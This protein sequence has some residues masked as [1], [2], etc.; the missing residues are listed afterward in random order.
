MADYTLT[1]FVNGVDQTAPA[2]QGMER[3]GVGGVAVGN[4]LADVAMKAGAAIAG[5][6][7]GTLDAAAQFQNATATFASVAGGALAEAGIS[8][9]DVKN[10][11]LEMGAV[12]Q[13]SAAEAQQAMIELAKGG[14]P[15]VDVMGQATDAT[16]NLAAAGEVQLATAA[17]IV[18]KQLGV[19]ASTGVTAAQV[20]DTLAQAANAST[21]GVEELALGLS[22][23]GGVAQVSGVSFQDLNQTLAMIIPGF[24][25]ASDAG[26]SFK[27]M[28]LALQGKSSDAIGVMQQLGII[29]TD[30]A[31]IADDLGVTFDGSGKS[32][33][34]LNKA[35]YENVL[36]NSGATAGTKAFDDAMA[37]FMGDFQV[38]TFYDANGAL[39]DMGDIAGILQHSLAGLSE[40]QKTAALNT[41][42]GTD[43]YR[44]AAF[45]AKAGAEGFDAMGVSMANAGTAAEQAA[46]RNQTFKF[47]WDSLLGTMET[48]QIVIGSMLLPILTSL[49]NDAL[50]PAGNAVL[51]VIQSLG[52]AGVMSSEFAESMDL[53][54]Q[55]LG[56]PAN[57]LQNIIIFLQGNFMPVIA[58]LGTAILVAVVPGFIAWAAVAGAAALATL[59]ALAPA[60]AIGAAVALLYVAWQNNFLGIQDIT[61][62]VWAT[63]QPYLV[64]LVDW[65]SVAIPAAIQAAAIL[66]STVLWPALQVV[67]EFII[68]TVIPALA[69]IVTWL[70][71]NIPPAIATAVAAFQTIIA[72][73]SAFVGA[74]AAGFA[75]A[76][77]SV[78]SGIATITTIVQAG[79]NTVIFVT[80]AAWGALWGVIGPTVN[81]IVAGVSAGLATI[82]GLWSAGWAVLEG[83]A[84]AAWAAITTA[85]QAAGAAI[86][87]AIQSVISFI[88]SVWGGAQQAAQAQTT[89]A[90]TAIQTM[91][92]GAML[93]IK[94]AI[95]TGIAVVQ[96]IMSTAWA[97]VVAAAQNDFGKIPAI[98]QAGW[99]R[100]KSIMQAGVSAITAVAGTMAAAALSLG[101]NIVSGILSGV[102]SMGS[103]LS[104]KLKSMAK[105]ALDAAKS[106]LGIKSPSSVMADQVGAPIAQGVA[107]GIQAATPKATAAMSDMAGK[108]VSMVSNSVGA[109]G[110]LAN[111]GA[112]PGGAIQR[113]QAAMIA[114]VQMLD[115]VNTVVGKGMLGGAMRL[116][117]GVNRVMETVVKGVEAFSKL[118]ELGT[119]PPAAM[120]HFGDAL[121]QV[122]VVL[123]NINALTRGPMLTSASIMAGNTEKIVGLIGTGAE[124]FTKL[125]GMGPVSVANVQAFGQ[126]LGAAIQEIA[127]VAG[128]LSGA[129]LAFAQAFAESASKIMGMIGPAVDG[130]NKLRTMGEAVPGSF[131]KFAQYMK[132]AVTR[133]GE[134]AQT[135][136]GAIVAAAARFAEGAGKVIS[137]LG[138]GVDGFAKLATLGDAV[139][140]M[141]QRFAVQVFALVMRIAEVGSWMSVEA[142]AK[143]AVFAD[144]AGKVIGIIGGGVEAFN[145]LKDFGPISTI[146]L[147]YFANAVGNALTR[148]VWVASTFDAQ[149]VAAAAVFAEGV[150]K[151]LGIIGGGVEGFTKLGDFGPVSTTALDYFANAIG[152][153][154]TR[155]VW[156]ASTFDVEGVKAAAIFA[157]GAG[158]VLGVIKSGIDGLLALKDIGAVPQ[159]G[160][161]A[162]ATAINQL[163]TRLTAI[164]AQFDAEGVKAAAAFA[165]AAGKSVGIL[166]V[167][168]EGLLLVNT[169]TDVSIDAMDRFGAGVRLAVAKMAQL[170]AEFGVDA[171]AAALNFAKAA[172]EATD[173]LK[174]GVDGFKKLG[175]L[176]AV[177]QEG[178]ALFA[179]GVI[180]LIN[181]IV[182]LSTVVSVDAL[183][184]AN[185]FS[186]AVDTVIQVVLGG[187][188][189]LNDLGSSAGALG[190]FAQGI[191]GSINTMAQAVANQSTPAARDIGL[192]ISYGIAD[193]ITAG[194]PAIQNAVF[195]AINAALAAARAALGIASPSKVFEQ[196]IGAQMSAGM[197]RGVLGGMPQVQAA[198]GA[199]STGAIGS[200]GGTTNTSS[201]TIAPGAITVNAQPG[202]DANAVA[203]AVM[204]RV[205]DLT[206]G[207]T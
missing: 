105:G 158:K 82:Q 83:V 135:I 145:K 45:I 127:R 118:A 168:V 72:G 136:D 61:A 144:G 121:Y 43:A 2:Q 146:A 184:V 80:S 189:A 52:E 30:Y 173:F 67:G 197:A 120:N 25:S 171:T 11:A 41:M 119:V 84:S 23:V 162:F 97:V 94:V 198:V 169:F 92:T 159:I 40:E 128:Q 42:F 99:D 77:A 157:E 124:A 57:M 204:R 200:T 112:I 104:D 133:V 102:S 156:V 142:V 47:A 140:G 114:V 125:A 148:L 95:Q 62:S 117:V 167:G 151:V 16:L 53:V 122:I 70:A 33:D 46:I 38:N 155:L 165:D 177:P 31:G 174:K 64:Q 5:M 96:N 150:G 154:I 161:D 10:K 123:N 7:A 36:A 202:Q 139:P 166:K 93:A 63:I 65:L 143:A 179:N 27:T 147:D 20:S 28:L 98:I 49:V 24:S 88:Q 115:A 51:G 206:R 110:Q 44:A 3:L 201:I 26:T 194:A 56:V 100:V 87:G 126:A 91:I 15:V 130:L 203:D 175:E 32:M 54:G 50:I 9:E 137:I 79:W 86:Q 71:T 17:E 58:G 18:A 55:S 108:L 101:K 69:Q 129:G 74:I 178:M 22:A 138:S 68:G 109:F 107:Q 207:H 134:A 35:I 85:V 153:T 6:A 180:G 113:F 90:W 73:I 1:I 187:L 152:N 199:V 76:S 39:K 13:F 164:A 75:T 8:L 4:I 81:Q 37:S 181:T 66:W 60:I 131:A 195:A 176:E 170:A 163:M 34:A 193:G 14:V 59:A 183:A 12:T 196:Q 111:L 106:A 89:A 160:L 48:I 19:W 190:T 132:V 149:G 141:F 182:Q 172:G 29:T 21:V 185:S 192:N 188:K 103:A 78:S 186:N 205:R 191:V 116:T